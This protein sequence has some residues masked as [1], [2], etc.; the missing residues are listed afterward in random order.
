MRH[1]VFAF[2]SRIQV[3]N[4]GEDLKKAVALQSKI[5]SQSL[6]KYLGK[7]KEDTFT[8]IEKIPKS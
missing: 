2:V 7:I 4:P 5:T 3:R 1:N 6:S 8:P